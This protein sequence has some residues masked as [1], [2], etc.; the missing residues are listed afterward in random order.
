MRTKFADEVCGR[1]LRAELR[2]RQTKKRP[3]Q[4][5]TLD[6]PAASGEEQKLIGEATAGFEPAIG[7]LQT[8]ALPLGHVATQTCNVDLN[9]RY[10][11]TTIADTNFVCTNIVN[12]VANSIVILAGGK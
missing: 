2:R 4:G 7:V 3:P 5:P 12:K 6:S 11:Y 8:P 9:V 10:G 1:R